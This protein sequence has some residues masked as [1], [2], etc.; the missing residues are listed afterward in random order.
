MMVVPYVNY[1]KHLCFKFFYCSFDWH[2]GFGLYCC[3]F[4]Y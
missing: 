2:N 3:H 1:F 4:H